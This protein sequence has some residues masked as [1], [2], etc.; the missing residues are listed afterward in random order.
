MMHQDLTKAVILKQLIGR[1]FDFVAD[2]HMRKY[3]YL[4]KPILSLGS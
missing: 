4:F 3:L 2:S 1:V